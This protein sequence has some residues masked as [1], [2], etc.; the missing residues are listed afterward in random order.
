MG[1]RYV[2]FG[3]SLLLALS[4]AVPAFG[5]PSNPVSKAAVSAK[6]ALKV[7]KQ[8]RRK[9]TIA[10]NAAKGAQTSA[11]QAETD[12]QKG[13]TDAA[14]AQAKANQAETDAQTGITN[15]ATAQTAANNAQT[16]ANSK[17]SGG[18][19][20]V[21]GTI[22]GGAAA[23]QN[24][25]ATCPSAHQVVTGGGFSLGG[26]HANEATVT[27]NQEFYQNS[28]FTTARTINGQADNDWTIQAEAT[29]A[30]D[31]TAP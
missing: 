12:A 30:T 8:A 7:A 31:P 11:N 18:G 26:T 16:T 4:L 21:N 19:V 25:G 17:M 28:W 5:G 13:I 15:A 1:K 22:S 23:T 24:S 2:V 3:A 6:R 14:T 29:C 10:L 9:A 27:A 20:L